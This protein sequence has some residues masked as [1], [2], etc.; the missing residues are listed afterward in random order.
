MLAICWTKMLQHVCTNKEQKTRHNNNNIIIIIFFTFLR[1]TAI[2]NID[3]TYEYT[4]KHGYIMEI[5]NLDYLKYMHSKILWFKN[6]KTYISTLLLWFTK[7]GP[8][9]NN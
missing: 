5:E 3:T 4:Q 6:T 8:L 1:E 7:P 2:Y 9:L